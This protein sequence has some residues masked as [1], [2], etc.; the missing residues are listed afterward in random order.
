MMIVMIVLWFNLWW[1]GT[2]AAATRWATILIAGL[3]LLLLLPS[4]PPLLPLLPA[5]L[6]LRRGQGAHDPRIFPTMDRF[7]RC[8]H[9]TSSCCQ[10]RVSWR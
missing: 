7:T 5:L 1:N 2:R 4:P 6:G 9:P 8:H 3:L 10:A